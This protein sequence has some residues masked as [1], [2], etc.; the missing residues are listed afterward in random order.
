MPRAHSEQELK[1]IRRLAKKHNWKDLILVY[2]ELTERYNYNKRYK[3]VISKMETQKPK[4]KAKKKCRPYKGT[5]HVGQKLQIDVKY[6]PNYCVVNGQKYYEYIAVDE[7][8]RWSYRQIYDEHSTYSSY[9]F[10]IALIKAAPFP[11]REA[12][13]DNGSKFTN[14]LKQRILKIQCLRRH[15]K[16]RNKI[17]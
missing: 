9:Q 4:K 3:R 13:T 15:K 5:D 11:I 12:Q 10:L 17:S 16:V 7:Y 14:A 8:S 1:L 2:H 6:V